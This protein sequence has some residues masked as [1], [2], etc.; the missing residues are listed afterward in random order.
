MCVNKIVKMA[1]KLQTDN[2]FRIQ[3]VQKN[4]SESNYKVVNIITKKINQSLKI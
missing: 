3:N 2:Q 1:L 4:S